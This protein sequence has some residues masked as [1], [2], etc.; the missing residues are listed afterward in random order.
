MS[1]TLH[2]HPFASYCWKA[3]IALYERD[4]PFERHFVGGPEDRAQ[5]S[6]LWPLGSIPVLVDSAG[7]TLPESTAIIE[8]LDRHGSAPP[9]I[10]AEPDAAI[11][12]RLWDR[13]MDGHVMTPMQK[14]VADALRPEG[15]EDPY[16]VEEARA[17]LDAAYA[18]L[19]DRLAGESRWLAG[20][21]FT[22]AD[23]AAAPALYYAR[24]VH[25]WDEAELGALTR[26]FEALTE[27]PSVARVIDEAREFRPVFPLPWPEHAG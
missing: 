26:Y 15:S 18:L 3:L 21:G 22:L 1:L 2:E 23:C 17:Q 19:D 24:V 14:I 6:Q 10:P 25:R 5:L 9:L 12:A 4:V 20:P 16:G 8:Y 27:R 11:R 13:L 7:P